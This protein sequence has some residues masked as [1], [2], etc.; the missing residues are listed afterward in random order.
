[1]YICII[2]A[3]FWLMLNPLCPSLLTYTLLCWFH[4]DLHL[5]CRARNYIHIY[6]VYCLAVRVNSV[7]QPV[8][9]EQQSIRIPAC[10]HRAAKYP[11][12]CASSSKVSKSRVP[13][14]WSY[15]GYAKRQREGA[16]MQQCAL[17][18]RLRAARVSHLGR[19]H[20]I[21]NAFASPHQL[22]TI[23]ESSKHLSPQ[24]EPFVR[25]CVLEATTS[26]TTP[27]GCCTVLH[28]AGT[29]QGGG[30][31]SLASFFCDVRATG[32]GLARTHL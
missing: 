7:S 31:P 30:A 32:C 15:G 8:S 28:G 19:S 4:F 24:A 11:S 6:S 13:C 18:A 22:G 16:I 9:T 26:M 25:Q 3:P 20:D 5:H 21:R 12:L 27:S 1:M 29:L 14:S 23:S 17:R 10:E 2:R